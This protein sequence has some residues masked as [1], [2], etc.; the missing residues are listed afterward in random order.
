[1]IPPRTWRR[2]L[3]VGL[4]GIV[5]AALL[6]GCEAGTGTGEIIIGSRSPTPTVVST[7]TPEP[8]TPT[9]VV[10]P[11]PTPAVI[12][13]TPVPATA[14]EIWVTFG[15]G[16]CDQGCLTLAE[17]NEL[18]PDGLLRG[19]MTIA[20]DAASPAWRQMARI[21]VLRHTRV[22]WAPLDPSVFGEY[23][24]FDNVILVNSDL[25]GQATSAFLA[26]ILAH[27]VYHAATLQP[28]RSA[29][30][31]YQGEAAAMSWGAYIYEQTRLGS[32]NPTLTSVLNDLPTAWHTNTLLPWVESIP[33]Y[34][35]ECA[36]YS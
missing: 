21:A 17:W 3:R 22:F 7:P 19:A 4:L 30:D 31:C 20:Y 27:E 14:T 5:L 25:Q 16:W 2:S 33:D 15:P 36:A 8:A 32:E 9:D 24:A 34:Q 1:M 35:R 23:R 6:T 29:L 11:D 12:V 18:I 26:E 13:Q 10:I 28:W